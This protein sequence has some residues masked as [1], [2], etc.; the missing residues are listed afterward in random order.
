MNDQGDGRVSPAVGALERAVSAWLES[1]RID[2]LG[3]WLERELDE[4]GVPKRLSIDDWWPCLRGLARAR[5][6]R[7]GWPQKLD[8]RIL[9]LTASILRFTRPDGSPALEQ[10]GAIGGVEA[11]ELLRQLAELFPKSREARVIA[12]MLGLKSENHVPPPLPAWSCSS[13][14]LSS[15]R[16]NWQKQGDLLALDQSRRTPVARLELIGAGTRWLGRDWRLA[17]VATTASP[18]RPVHW[19]SNSVAD[20]A[21]WTYRAN[22]MRLARTAPDTPSLNRLLRKSAGLHLQFGGLLTAGLL[23]RA[24]L[25]RL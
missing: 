22:G 15:L 19:L 14:A 7:R 12:W 18:A 5:A 2:L 23:A 21:E 1:S 24:A 4:G 3:R 16:E 8:T 17:N 20:L 13:R 25:D 6:E 11:R 9:G 10:D